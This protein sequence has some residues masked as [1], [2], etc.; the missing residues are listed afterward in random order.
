MV[1]ASNSPVIVATDYSPAASAAVAAG[2]DLARR[3]GSPLIAVHVIAGTPGGADASDIWG[4]GEDTAKREQQR[5]E[6]H[7]TACGGAPGAACDA[8][9][10]WGE[11]VAALRE[12]A[13]RESPLLI[14]IGRSGALGGGED[15]IG[16]VAREL[17]R[18]APCPVVLCAAAPSAAPSASDV[19]ADTKTVASLMRPA[20]VTIGQNEALDRVEALMRDAGVHQLP[21]VEDGRLIG[22]VTRHD[23]IRQTGYWEQTKV[24]AVM[25]QNPVCVTPATRLHAAITLLLDEDINALPV[26]AEG[27]LVGMLSKTDILRFAARRLDA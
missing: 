21:V 1:G 16:A 14:T 26:V 15:G 25:T 23:L 13:A 22:I 10:L 7:L 9:V 5:L 4:S 6:Q 3:L 19:A 11:P 8:R 18:A 2:I 24:D 12:L 17:V 20:P 27:T